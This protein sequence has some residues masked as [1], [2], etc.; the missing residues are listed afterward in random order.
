MSAASFM[1]GFVV[2]SL[3]AIILI[4]LLVSLFIHT[5]RS[6]STDDGS[7]YGGHGGSG[8]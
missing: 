2:Y 6:D 1:V 8:D 7:G 4:G 3:M 5:K